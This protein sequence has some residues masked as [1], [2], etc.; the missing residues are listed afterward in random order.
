MIEERIA[1][2]AAFDKEAHFQHAWSGEAFANAEWTKEY[3]GGKDVLA[4]PGLTEGPWAGKPIVR[5]D[6][7]MHLH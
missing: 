5:P 3:G 7:K 1:D 2:P 6:V 4:D